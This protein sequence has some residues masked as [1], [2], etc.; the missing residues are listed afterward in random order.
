MKSSFLP[1]ISMLTLL[2]LVY[3][4][5]CWGDEKISPEPEQIAEQLRQRYA[6]I[7][8]L[9]FNFVQQTSGE[10]AG[11]SKRG[12]GRALFS[13][14]GAQPRMRWDYDEPD[15]QVI[16][17]DGT[18]VSMYFAQLNQQIIAPVEQAQ[19]D[20]LFSF[21]SGRTP[22]AESFL[23]TDADDA[24]LSRLASLPSL[25][26]IRLQPLDPRTNISA[27]HLFITD[28]YLIERLVITDFFD[29]VTIID[30]QDVS[31][32]PL[33]SEDEGAIAALFTFSPPEGTEIIYQ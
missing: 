16:I 6:G 8:S 9:R 24:V 32:D 19:T 22:L 2:V 20:L 14:Q 30:I 26:V 23:I 17:S 3:A 11:R 28:E 33:A 7:E 13:S 4:A 31:I 25:R 29:T 5:T 12:A 21:F 27:V 18:T 15:Y 1:L 10:M